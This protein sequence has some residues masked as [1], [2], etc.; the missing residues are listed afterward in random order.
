[1]TLAIAKRR[2]SRYVLFRQQGC[3]VLRTYANQASRKQV[4]ACT[5]SVSALARRSLWQK[6]LQVFQEFTT[7]EGHPLDIVLVNAIITTSAIGHQWQQAIHWI[8][9]CSRLKLRPTLV[10]HSATMSACL[11][12]SQ[13][14]RSLLFFNSLSSARLAADNT[15]TGTAISACSVRHLSA[16][17]ALN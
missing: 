1:M 15:I 17:T 10:T 5:A 8:A 11:H 9:S 13:W 16:G 4:V 3:Q 7:E 2:L 12:G 6:A 14:E